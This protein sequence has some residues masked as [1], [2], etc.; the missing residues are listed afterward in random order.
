MM[1]TARRGSLNALTKVVLN[2]INDQRG[3]INRIYL[4]PC[5]GLRVL[6]TSSCQDGLLLDMLRC[7]EISLTTRARPCEL[8][9]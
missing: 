3:V 8:I 6:I 1:S 9:S 4:C 2:A 5:Q 7:A